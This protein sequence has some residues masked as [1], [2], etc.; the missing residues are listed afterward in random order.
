MEGA[1]AG[2][3]CRVGELLAAVRVCAHKC[4]YVGVHAYLQCLPHGMACLGA[5]K[6]EMFLQGYE[7][8]IGLVLEV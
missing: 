5:L 6:R 2:L 3:P 7:L 8:G 1:S 4:S